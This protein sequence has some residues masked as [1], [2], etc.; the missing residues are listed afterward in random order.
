MDHFLRGFD[1]NSQTGME[2]IWISS[3]MHPRTHTYTHT[4]AYT[5]LNAHTCIQTPAFTHLRVITGTHTWACTHRY[6]PKGVHPQAHTN[7]RPLAGTH[8]RARTCRQKSGR[9]HKQKCIQKSQNCGG[10]R[11]CEN[12][13]LAS[14]WV[15]RNMIL[16]CLGVFVRELEPK[17][18][19]KTFQKWP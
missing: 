2:K 19:K 6:T 13:R 16:S 12:W 8:P 5:H 18:R 7:T 1:W 11:I 9:N 15:W 14:G 3:G 4:H 17:S 10:F